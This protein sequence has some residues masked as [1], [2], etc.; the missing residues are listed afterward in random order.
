MLE[1]NH[2]FLQIAD[3]AI[4]LLNHRLG[5]YFHF[6]TDFNGCYNSARDCVSRIQDGSIA[7]NDLAERSITPAGL[8]ALP[9]IVDVYNSLLGG[10]CGD[11]LRRT[12]QSHQIFVK[13]HCNEVAEG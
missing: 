7:R 9:F 13:V 12:V 4:D 2:L 11:E 3:N 1:L 8:D 6:D 10:D 5:K